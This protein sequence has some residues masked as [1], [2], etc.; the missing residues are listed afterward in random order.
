LLAI[1][2]RSNLNFFEEVLTII[3][4]G[5]SASVTKHKFPKIIGKN[6]I[7]KNVVVMFPD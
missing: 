1:F 4:I 2:F 5:T 3:C 6:K 7:R